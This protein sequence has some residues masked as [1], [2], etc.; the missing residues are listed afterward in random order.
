MPD[1]PAPEPPPRSLGVLWVVVGLLV[2]ALGALVVGLAEEGRD[3][4]VG[5]LLLVGAA[6]GLV[7]AAVVLTRARGAVLVS[8]AASALVFAGGLTAIFGLSTGAAVDLAVFGGLPVLGG[9]ATALVA[10]LSGSTRTRPRRT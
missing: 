1:R 7:A 5:S 8:R 2:G 9:I 6:A 4:F 10:G 3:R